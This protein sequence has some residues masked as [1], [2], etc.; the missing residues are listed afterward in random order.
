MKSN[1]KTATAEIEVEGLCCAECAISIEKVLASMAGIKEL[2]VLPTSEKLLLTYDTGKLTPDEIVKRI[3]TLGYRVKDK[4]RDVSGHRL[5]EVVILAFVATI[6]IFVTLEVTFE[7]FGLLELAQ[8]PVPFLIIATLVGGFSIFRKA[9]EGIRSKR[10]TADLLMSIAIIAALSIREFSAALLIVFFM[11]IAHFLEGFTVRKS[12]QAVD[13]LTKLVPKTARIKTGESEVEI[14]VDEVRIGDVV[15]VRPGERVPIDGIVLRGRSS[16]DQSSIT[17]ESIPAEKNVGDVVFAGTINQLGMLEISVKRVGQD[18]TLGRII[19][20]VEQAEASKAP[21]QKF[22]DKYSSYYLPVVI[23]ASLVTF[24]VTRVPTYAIAVLV[25]TCP[26]AIALATPLAVVASVGS[27]AKKGMLIKG[28]LFLDK[29]AKVDTVIVDKTG[30][31]TLGRPRVTDIV[32]FADVSEVELVR[33]AAS[34]ERYS[35]HPLSSALLDHAEKCNVQL[36]AIDDFE[37][38]PGKGI[39][40]KL[41]G[42]KVIVGNMELLNSENVHFKQNVV[43]EKLQEFEEQGKTALFVAVDSRLLGM[44]TVADV[45]R[46][47]VAETLGELKGMGIKE[48]ILLT[49][50]NE[51]VAAAIARSL[52]IS[53]FRANVLP[54]DKIAEV[55]SLQAQGRIVAMIGDGVND[56]PAL[57]QADIGIAMGTRGSDVAIEAAPLVLMRDDWM[58]IPVAVRIVRK[59]LITIKQNVAFGILFNMTGVILASLGVLPPILA[60]AAQSLP[61]VVV[62]LNS[63]R[64]LRS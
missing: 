50:D 44:I 59:S 29:L 15:V 13:E 57:A 64:L 14:P 26:C 41:R 45:V 63:S 28:G 17:G 18:T 35:E 51:R 31:L 23:I 42:S 60:A 56:A 3:Q 4:K 62:F 49:G 46:S 8:I 1:E 47:G 25:V 22:A 20:L 34:A 27:L 2:K 7:R 12:R 53:K 24:L 21:I 11:N 54:E 39:T 58:Q 33:L 5:A 43:A 19:A 38:H 6:A 32:M 9:F 30:T 48:I 36:E 52:G 10:I 16:V 61:D 40:C 37:A 55:R